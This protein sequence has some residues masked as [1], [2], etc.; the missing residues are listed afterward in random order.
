MS[1]FSPP[2]PGRDESKYVPV[3]WK[4]RAHKTSNMAASLRCFRISQL[5]RPMVADGIHSFL[6]KRCMVFHHRCSLSYLALERRRSPACSITF[7]KYGME[8]FVRSREKR[9]SETGFS[10]HSN[11]QISKWIC[12]SVIV[13][14]SFLE[15]KCKKELC[16]KFCGYKPPLP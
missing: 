13:S 4:P 3:V 8:T 15:M 6:R 2:I 10:S 16:E 9:L 7:G 5:C 12:K 11:P 14:Y 1:L